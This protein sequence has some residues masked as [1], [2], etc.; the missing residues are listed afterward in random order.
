MNEVLEAT[1]VMEYTHP[2]GRVVNVTYFNNKQ[3][4]KFRVFYSFSNGQTWTPE[5]DCDSPTEWYELCRR[6][7]ATMNKPFIYENATLF[8]APITEKVGA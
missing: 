3:P 1:A 4:K 7:S 6:N 2:T 8:F 5:A